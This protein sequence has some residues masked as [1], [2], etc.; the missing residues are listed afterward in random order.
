MTRLFNLL[1]CGLVLLAGYASAENPPGFHTLKIGDQAPDFTLPGIDDRNW[2]LNDFREFDVLIVYFTSN[3]CPVCHAHDPRLLT[4]LK[5][6]EGKSVGIVAINPNSG[7]G[8]R[9]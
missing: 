7:D 4:L 8:L 5:E 9:P 6:L 3:H 1:V 2:S